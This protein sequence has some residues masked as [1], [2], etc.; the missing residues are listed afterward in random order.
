ME[1]PA[2]PKPL[3][4]M[5]SLPDSEKREDNRQLSLIA[6]SMR[7][8]SRW[9]SATDLPCAVKLLTCVLTFVGVVLGFGQYCIRLRAIGLMRAAGMVL[10]GNGSRMNCG[11]VALTGLVESKFGL[12]RVVSGS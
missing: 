12:A 2:F 5:F 11:F 3:N 8:S 4:G 1:V 6:W 7:R 10:F 9:L